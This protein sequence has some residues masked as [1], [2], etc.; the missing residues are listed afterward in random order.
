M[1]MAIATVIDAITADA[2]LRLIFRML[3]PPSLLVV[4]LVVR[5]AV[6]GAVRRSTVHNF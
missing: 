5:S 6:A 4:G 3:S 1:A 2:C